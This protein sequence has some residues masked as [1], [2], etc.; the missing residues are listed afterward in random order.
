MTV[1]V[2]M[3]SGPRNISTAMMRSFGARPDTH[4]T[5]EPLYAHYL[6]VTG[7]AHPGR[8]EVIAAHETDWRKVAA[9]LT[10]PVPDGR[11]V[12]Y[13]KHMAHHLL[14]MIDRGWLDSLTHAFLIREPDEMVASLL[15]TYPDAGLADTGLPQQA[16][17]FDRIASRLGRAPPVIL[18]SDVLKDP[19]AQLEALCAALRIRW[20]DAM[21]AWEPGRRATDGAWA[22]HWYSAVEASTGF[23]PYRRRHAELDDAQARLVDECLPYYEKL[24]ALRLKP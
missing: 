18:A 6:K 14:P 1:R 21:L 13:Q 4:V 8:D 20:T 9:W 15:R 24:F 16:E 7:V 11:E 22:P 5:D 23:E 17:I 12:W 10:G 19:R 3:W 2:A